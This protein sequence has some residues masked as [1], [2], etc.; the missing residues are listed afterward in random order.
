MCLAKVVEYKMKNPI[1]SQ[2]VTVG[3]S[4]KVTTKEDIGGT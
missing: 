2:S 4:G 3:E 1:N